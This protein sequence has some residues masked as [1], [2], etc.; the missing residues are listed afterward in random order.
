MGLNL[1]TLPFRLPLMPL[2]GFVHLAE[3]IN[4]QVEQ[5]FHDPAR[6]RRELE[7]VQR[8]RAAGKISAE[9]AAR[10][11]QEATSKL[12]TPQQPARALG[13]ENRRRA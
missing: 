1:L 10:I 5:E 3:I 9:E 7:E 2:K 11:E 8:Q 13:D 6:V 12:V 4:D